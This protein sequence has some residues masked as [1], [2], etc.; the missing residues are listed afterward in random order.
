MLKDKIMSRLTTMKNV[1]QTKLD[2]DKAVITFKS[3][4][5]MTLDKPFCVMIEMAGVTSY[6][7]TPTLKP[8][9]V[10]KKTKKEKA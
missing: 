5:V 10:K 8:K 2:V 9:E 7:L 6:S 4:T 1:K 3:G